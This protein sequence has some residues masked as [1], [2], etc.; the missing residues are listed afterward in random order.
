MGRPDNWW[1][2]TGFEV[3]EVATGFDLP[4]N[5][6]FVPHPS[7]DPD[8]PLLYVTELYGNVKVVTNDRTVHTFAS[9]LLNYEASYDIPGSGESGVTGICVKPE[10]GDVY[11]SLVYVSGET[12]LGKVVRLRS[13]DGLRAD[14]AETV[15]DN[16]PSTTKAHQVQAVTFGPDGM[17]YVNVGDGGNADAAQQM[18]D[19]RGK[20]LR[21]NADG[22]VPSDNPTPGSPVYAF[23]FRNPFGAAWRKSDRKLYVS[24]NGP[25]RDDVLARVDAGTNHGWPMTMRKNSLFVWEYTQA[26]TALAFAED[27][28]FG[29]EYD[30]H[31]FVALFGNSY[32]RGRD[33]KGKKIVKMKVNDGGRGVLTYDE[34]V[35][36]TGNGPASPCGLA[37]GPDGLYF[38]DLHGEPGNGDYHGAGAIYR[39]TRLPKHATSE[40]DG[41]M[42]AESNDYQLVE[43]YVYFPPDSVAWNRFIRSG[44]TLSNP[45]LGNGVYWN[46][47]V[48]DKTVEDGAWSY[49]EP[50]PGAAH[51][52]D[53]VAFAY[54]ETSLRTERSG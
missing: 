34:F 33:V 31:L 21:L 36:Y 32:K 47:V 53:Y 6:A 8:S 27:G 3:E 38:T 39:V 48:G 29:E 51:I 16:I 23:G 37:F 41:V 14:S 40:L 35:T 13:A 19:L 45:R 28:V 15:L 26:P 49:T 43:S 17:L 22:L 24:I 46:I 7:N 50:R 44:R 4:V 30:D 10:T 2:F 12:V 11:I 18:D 25:D 52:K 5:L 42:L 54:G 20:V 1:V 9:G